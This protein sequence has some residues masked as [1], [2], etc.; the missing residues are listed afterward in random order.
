[1]NLKRDKEKSYNL[2]NKRFF[3]KLTK[4][5]RPIGQYKKI[6]ICVIRDSEKEEKEGNAGKKFEEMMAENFSN[7][8]SDINLQ[9]QEMNSKQD[10]FKQ[11]NQTA[12]T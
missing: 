8:M 9:I 2:I 5:E 12:E 10:K 3:K 6:L 1:M 11:H 4:P 7:L